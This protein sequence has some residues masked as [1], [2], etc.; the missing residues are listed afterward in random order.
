MKILRCSNTI[1][2]I[3]IMRLMKKY[4]ITQYIADNIE[5]HANITLNISLLIPRENSETLVDS[6]TIFPS[7]STPFNLCL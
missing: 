4:I 3:K 2:N 1:K 5:Y 6:G 7:Y